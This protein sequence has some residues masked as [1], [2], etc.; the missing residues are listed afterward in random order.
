MSELEVALVR[1]AMAQVCALVRATTDDKAIAQLVSKR[2]KLVVTPED[3]A[4]ERE[5]MRL[6]DALEPHTPPPPAPEPQP[7]TVVD[8]WSEAELARSAESH[9]RHKLQM[10]LSSR[11]LVTAMAR[12][13]LNCGLLLPHMTPEHM[14]QLASQHLSA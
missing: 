9:E 4:I 6:V 13:A 7:E 8:G 11:A 12:E 5:S 14:R 10:Y 1:K 3:V 2:H